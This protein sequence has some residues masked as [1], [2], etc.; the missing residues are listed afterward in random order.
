M[1]DGKARIRIFPSNYI[2][3]KALIL[4]GLKVEV[5]PVAV[6]DNF[7]TAPSR[8]YN[9]DTTAI[10]VWKQ[11]MN[12]QNLAALAQLA[13]GKLEDPQ[14]IFAVKSQQENLFTVAIMSSSLSWKAATI[15]NLGCTLDLNPDTVY[16]VSISLLRPSKL[17]RNVQNHFSVSLN[18]VQPVFND[19]HV[20]NG[21]HAVKLEW[22]LHEDF[23]L[24]DLEKSTKADGEYKKLNTIPFT[25]TDNDTSRS[26][27]LPKVNYTDTLT[28]NYTKQYYRVVAYNYF[29][30]RINSPKIYEGMGID[31][32]PPR[33]IDSLWFTSNGEHHVSVEWKKGIDPDVA[34][35]VV[36]YGIGPEGPWKPL[37][38][39][40]PNVRVYVH[41]S[42]SNILSN[43]YRVAE[44]DSVN[45]NMVSLPVMAVTKDTI[46]PL[47]VSNLS[48]TIEKN[49]IAKLSWIPS[50]SEDIQGYRIFRT[51]SDSTG[52]QALNGVSVRDTLFTDTVNIKINQG[53]ILY[54]VKAVDRKGNFGELVPPVYL[55][56]PDQNPP[57]QPQILEIVPEENGTLS[58]S[59][60]F[61]KSEL[62]SELQMRRNVKA[63]TSAWVKIA[64]AEHYTDTS[65]SRKNS[66]A[67][68]IRLIDSS[69]N[70]SAPS[71]WFTQRPLPKLIKLADYIEWSVQYDQLA[72]HVAVKW[73]LKKSCD[74]CKIFFYRGEE[75]TY[76]I[77]NK[78]IKEGVW[79]DKGF[80][81]A[82]YINYQIQIKGL[83]E[84]KSEL[85]EKK[86]VFTQ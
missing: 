70:I 34:Q 14:N 20:M 33:S 38:K 40:A 41:D 51:K 45:N 10:S 78:D 85:S 22:D 16:S 13:Y 3:T 2:Q 62:K 4:S 5:Q 77:G 84:S 52:W 46:P 48:G 79:I 57:A 12:D 19:V 42:A 36:Y 69:G 17:I 65:V 64:L 37:A 7:I 63:D 47:P 59:F 86:T 55:N 76:L 15:S 75:S 71:S 81:V 50:P 80:P 39:L 67:Y 54:S 9:I 82:G 6:K 74:Q 61:N 27:V 1:G 26:Q 24:Y 29:G 32:T 21:E 49:G 72:K 28:E 44:Y 83:E 8:T 23:I 56:L 11:N 68:Q 31:K 66:Y 60:A 35:Q 53:K 58:L 25:A 30:E 43:Y 73:S 18:N